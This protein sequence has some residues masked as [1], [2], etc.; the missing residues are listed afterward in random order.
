[1]RSFK[2]TFHK[3]S[4][5]ESPFIRVLRDMSDRHNPLEKSSRCAACACR[6]YNRLSNL[7]IKICQNLRAFTEAT[8]YCSMMG[9]EERMLQPSS[10]WRLKCPYSGPDKKWVEKLLHSLVWAGSSVGRASGLN[11][12]KW[13]PL[14]FLKTY[15]RS[16]V[17]ILSCPLRFK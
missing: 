7:A 14:I 13:V 10:C 1:M 12:G 9:S 16:E 3:A 5:G 6:A 8:P 11:S 4:K 17:Q 15:R 2:R